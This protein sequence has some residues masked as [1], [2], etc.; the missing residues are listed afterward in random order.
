MITRPKTNKAPDIDG[1]K[2]KFPC[3]MARSGAYCFE[4]VLEITAKST[5]V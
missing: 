1:W 4:K 5:D 3:G 2:L